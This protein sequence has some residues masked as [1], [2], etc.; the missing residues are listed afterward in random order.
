[1]FNLTQII[2]KTSETET[3]CEKLICMKEKLENG[4]MLSEQECVMLLQDLAQLRYRHTVKSV[5]NQVV[6]ILSRSWSTS[7]EALADLTTARRLL[8]WVYSE[9]KDLADGEKD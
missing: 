3:T 2:D 9:Y 8:R 1:M 7:A 4:K 6:E 5:Q